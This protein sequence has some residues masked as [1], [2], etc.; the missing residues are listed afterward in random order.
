MK[1]PHCGL[2]L[3]R[4]KYH[5]LVEI[6]QDGD[7]IAHVRWFWCKNCERHFCYTEI[8]RLFESWWNK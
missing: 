3:S 4:P 1:C 6:K 8:F 5:R 7:V 2:E